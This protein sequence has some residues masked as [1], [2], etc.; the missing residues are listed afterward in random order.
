MAPPLTLKDKLVGKARAVGTLFKILVR[1]LMR[2][3]ELIRLYQRESTAADTLLEVSLIAIEREF[4]ERI[5]A[6]EARVAQLE[7][8]VAVASRAG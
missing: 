6:L 5:D 3:G 4:Q 2:P 1:F 8:Q 7:E